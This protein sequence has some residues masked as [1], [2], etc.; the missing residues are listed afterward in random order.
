MI[1]KEM[2]DK[3]GLGR[4][5][6]IEFELKDKVLTLRPKKDMA[7]IRKHLDRYVGSMAGNLQRD[8]YKSVDAY[9]R[10]VRSR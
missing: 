8:G 7:A 10:V 4:N 5:I 9:M 3:L 2:R 6:R 1:P